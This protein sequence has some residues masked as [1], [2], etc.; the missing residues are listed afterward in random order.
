M[1]TRFVSEFSGAI[2]KKKPTNDSDSIST[3]PY[4]EEIEIIQ[5]SNNKWIKI[6]W[7]EKTGWIVD[8][9]LPL[10]IDYSVEYP[11]YSIRM[12]G[13]NIQVWAIELIT[14]K[15][16]RLLISFATYE[17][18][19]SPTEVELRSS[20]INTPIWTDA[21]GNFAITTEPADGK[22]YGLKG[23]ISHKG[24]FTEY[25]GELLFDGFHEVYNLIENKIVLQNSI[26][27]K[28]TGY[29]G[30]L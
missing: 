18:W 25:E 19:K 1:G 4:G 13:T 11:Q 30:E 23:K 14:K 10:V 16:K 20:G 26:R 12:P 17:I 7:K 27:F 9:S 28:G 2:L 24:P 3:I 22:F 5:K 15:N 8:K 6:R 29:P 21:D